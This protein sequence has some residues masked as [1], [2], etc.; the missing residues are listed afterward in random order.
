MVDVVVA[1]AAPLGAKSVS[2]RFSDGVGVRVLEPEG[3]DLHCDVRLDVEDL[4][5][6]SDSLG[7]TDV[8][9]DDDLVGIHINGHL[10]VVGTAAF[11]AVEDVL[12]VRFYDLE[13]LDHDVAVI[14][15][16]FDTSTFGPSTTPGCNER[17]SVIW[18]IMIISSVLDHGQVI[19]LECL[20]E[21]FDGTSLRN[22]G[23]RHHGDLLGEQCLLLNHDH[24]AGPLDDVLDDLVDRLLLEIQVDQLLA[25]GNRLGFGQFFLG[26]TFENLG[27]FLGGCCLLEDGRRVS[28]AGSVSPS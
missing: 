10:D 4:D 11:D 16:R 7:V 2:M 21:Q 20:E 5:E 13:D 24:L 17:M 19:E 9:F 1:R 3:L 18:S 15:H 14:L 23:F 28:G 27:V 25:S 6:A 26:K 12:G 8:A 22:L